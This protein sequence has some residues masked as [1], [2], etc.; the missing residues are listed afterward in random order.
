[1]FTAITAFFLSF[2]YRMRGGG[3]VTLG[4]D[5]DCRLIWAAGM[6]TVYAVFGG[7][8]FWPIAAIIMA[9][10]LSMSV[11]HAYCQNMGRWAVPQQKWPSFFMPQWTQQGWSAAPMWQRALYDAAQMSA[12]ALFRGLLVFGSV[13]FD[14]ALNG[15]GMAALAHFGA[16]LSAI[17]VLQPGG[18]LL[19]CYGTPISIGPSLVKNTPTWGEFWNG[20]AWALAIAAAT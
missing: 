8:H 12:V 4:S 14:N 18:Y 13:F 5:V 11:P 1:M 3:F 6:G 16:G 9:S 2:L 15:G 19:G 20:A 7:L 17:M 10:F